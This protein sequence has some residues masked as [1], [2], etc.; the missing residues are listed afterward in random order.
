MADSPP[1]P[2][3]SS[4]LAQRPLDR[5]A[6]ERVLARAAEL[7][8]GSSDI[9]ESLT[10]E[11]IIELGREVGI[12]A[13]HL[14]QALAE[15]R[16]RI[17]LPEEGGI[18]ARIA[19]PGVVAA[20][21]VVKGRMADILADLD[22]WMHKEECLQVRRRQAD[23]VVWEPRRD[24]IAN[25]RRQLNLG[26]RGYDLARAG[27][28]AASV[29]QLDESRTHVRLEADL[30]RPRA[31]RIGSGIAV[32]GTGGVTSLIALGVVFSGAMAIAAPFLPVVAAAA[33]LPAAVG[34][35]GGY[36]TARGHRKQ[37]E[38]A[39]VALEQLLDRLEHGD[40]RRTPSL[41]DM[42]QSGKPKR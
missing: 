18:A 35:I 15:E 39:L 23:R 32:A 10:E 22:A 26:G 5:S 3:S 31:N 6:L 41:L 28:V 37:A 36:T 16:T 27:A 14:T 1:P 33:L 42:L 11:Q 38:R 7:Q 13:E 20:G 2:S 29:T 34:G 40:L 9:S 30:T 4:A 19:G 17:A 24:I 12:T 21:R 8:A 25:V